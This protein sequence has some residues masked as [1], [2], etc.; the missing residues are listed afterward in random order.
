ML[1]REE[2]PGTGKYPRMVFLSALQVSYLKYQDIKGHNPVFPNSGS[3]IIFPGY[4]YKYI[5]TKSS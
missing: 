3:S 2:D 5:T 1:S 4:S